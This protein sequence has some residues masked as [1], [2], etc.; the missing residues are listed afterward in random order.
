MARGE[1]VTVPLSQ[2]PPQRVYGKTL[3]CYVILVHG[4]NDAGE[5]YPFQ[6]KGAVLGP[7]RAP[8]AGPMTSSPT[9]TGR[10]GRT[11]AIRWSRCRTGS[12]PTAWRNPVPTAP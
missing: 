11:G 5:A 1:T 9:P 3:P 10:P 6:E 12:T 4:V 2:P 8:G 7:S